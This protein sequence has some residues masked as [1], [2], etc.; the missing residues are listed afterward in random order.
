MAKGFVE[1]GGIWAI[2]QWILMC[3]MLGIP[4]WWAGGDFGP[5][6]EVL[7]IVLL[8]AGAFFGIAGAV[9]LGKARTIYPEPRSGARLVRHGIFRVVRHPLYSSLI[10]L[11]FGWSLAW[12]S[13]AGVVA[14]LVMAAFLDAKARHEE[15]RLRLRFPDYEA[16]AARVKR[17]LPWLY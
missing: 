8:V 2:V 10:F 12:H 9:A 7:A 1:R 5:I 14:A 13:G 4:P 17:L 3:G 16:Y 6:A 15:Q 11:S